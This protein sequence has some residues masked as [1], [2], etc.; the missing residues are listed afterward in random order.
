MQTTT[1]KLKPATKG[2]K[3]TTNMQHNFEVTENDNKRNVK[4]P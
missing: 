3:V 4:W 1:N 2:H